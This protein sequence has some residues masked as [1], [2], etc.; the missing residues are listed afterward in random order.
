MRKKKIKNR[1]PFPKGRT[2]SSNE[3]FRDSGYIIGRNEGLRKRKGVEEEVG[4]G[5]RG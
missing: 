3:K 2:L 5:G 1:F 4:E